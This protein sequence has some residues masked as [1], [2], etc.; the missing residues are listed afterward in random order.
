MTGT[1]GVGPALFLP[2]KN[3]HTFWSETADLPEYHS[4]HTLPNRTHEHDRGDANHNAE[5]GEHRTRKIR[6]YARDGRAESIGVAH[7]RM[8]SAGTR[9]FRCRV[10]ARTR[11]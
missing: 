4:F 3:D 10:R 7:K 5:H 8:G 1:H 11:A 6:A 9:E 2:G